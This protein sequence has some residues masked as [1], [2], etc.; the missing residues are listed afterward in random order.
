[1]NFLS[2]K[3]ARTH[4][5][6][7]EFAIT[8]HFETNSSS[9]STPNWGHVSLHYRL[10]NDEYTTLKLETWVSFHVGPFAHQILV[11]M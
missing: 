9:H 3:L 10:P 7:L 11:E 6:S 1:M 8:T 5:Q 4:Y 2:Q